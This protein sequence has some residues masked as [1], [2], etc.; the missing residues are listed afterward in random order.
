VKYWTVLLVPKRGG[1]H[2]VKNQE[3]LEIFFSCLFAFLVLAAWAY[4][5]SESACHCEA[6]VS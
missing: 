5:L 6:R 1:T 4:G 2:E 3:V